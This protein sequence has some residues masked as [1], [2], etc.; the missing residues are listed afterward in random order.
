MITFLSPVVATYAC[1]VIPSLRE[2][3]THVEVIAGGVSLLGVTLIAR[4]AVIFGAP[5]GEGGG[6]E[7]VTP[8]QRV[9][10]VSVAL[11]GVF[12]AAAAYTCIR[13]IGK[14]AHPLISVFYFSAICC[15]ISGV[16][17]GVLPGVGGVVWPSGAVQWGLLGGIGVTG[18][19]M[20]FL[21]TSG[22]QREKAGR[23]TSVLYTQMVFALVWERVVWGTSPGG[24][25]CVGSGLVFGS[26][27]WVG[28]RKKSVEK[29]LIGVMG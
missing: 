17:L 10:A 14:R 20:Q 3:F 5:E 7:G 9:V 27:V 25:S 4:P 6:V 19:V 8:E 24:W 22:L 13:W 16:G 29:V 26:A 15:V 1:S 23:G 2:P 18:F 28:T 21:L 12:G 11:V